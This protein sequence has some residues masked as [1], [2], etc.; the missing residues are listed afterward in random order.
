MTLV[1][2][3]Y[4]P[5]DVLQAMM[6]SILGSSRGKPAPLLAPAAQWGLRAVKEK[7]DDQPGVRLAEVMTGG[8]AAEAGLKEGDRL[9]TLDGRWTD[10]VADLF[11]AAAHIPP[12]TLVKAVVR[13]GNQER[14]FT[15]RPVGGF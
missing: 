12:G 9:L 8:A 14:T 6:E 3:G 11:Q 4:Q 7:D 13:R 2:N 5:P 1:P 10:S 15:V